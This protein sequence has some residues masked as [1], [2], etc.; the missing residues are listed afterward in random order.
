[1]RSGTFGIVRNLSKIF[2]QDV[3]LEIFRRMCLVRYFESGIIRAVKE[4][5]FAYPLYLSS[6]QEAIAAAMSL[7]IP[8]FMIFAQHRC[9][10]TYLS[11]GGDPVKLREELFGLPGGTSGGRAGSNC[12]QCHENNI[13]MYGHH[14][15]IGENVPLAVGAALGCGKPTV[16]FFGDGAAEEDYVFAAMGFAVSHK[17]P[18]LFVCEDNNLSILTTV[19]TRRSWSMTNVATA[20]GM[21]GIDITDDPWTVFR[22]TQELKNNLPA[23]LNIYTCRANW[24]VGTG[25]DGPPEWDRYSMVKQELGKIG[26]EEQVQEIEKETQIQMEKLWDQEQLQILSGK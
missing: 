4:G 21:P 20:L 5:T 7:V 26:L 8:E 1:M 2:N 16:C 24:H 25:T 3:S 10:A 6:G 15:L 22:R 11:F 23:F 17:L 19:D 13:A 9:H 14:G 12:I 18:V